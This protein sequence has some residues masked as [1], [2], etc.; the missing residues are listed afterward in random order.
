MPFD[1]VVIVS[2]GHR[3]SLESNPRRLLR[4]FCNPSGSWKWPSVGAKGAANSEEIHISALLDNRY[5]D[6]S[7]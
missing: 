1:C 4:A 2:T 7:R 5:S 6:I 3:R